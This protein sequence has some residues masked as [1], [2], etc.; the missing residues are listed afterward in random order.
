VWGSDVYTD[1]SSICTAAV[2]AGLI[3]FASGGT[4]TI[5]IR[6]GQASYGATSRYGVA[7]SAYG[8][9]HGSYVFARAGAAGPAP[10][11]APCP[12]GIT[13]FGRCVEVPGTR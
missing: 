1:D 12:S 10:A 6:P 9:W 7:T 11:S 3:S 4:V 5:E 8:N 2:H 13:L